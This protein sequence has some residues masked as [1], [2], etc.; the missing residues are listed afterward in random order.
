MVDPKIGLAINTPV[1][2]LTKYMEY[3]D[4]RP[5]LLDGMNV[6]DEV[7]ETLNELAL[8]LFGKTIMEEIEDDLKLSQAYFNKLSA[9]GVPNLLLSVYG[10]YHRLRTTLV[11][12]LKTSP[13]SILDSDPYSLNILPEARPIPVKIFPN[14]TNPDDLVEK[15]QKQLIGSEVSQDI[16]NDLPPIEWTVS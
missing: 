2:R 9:M 6:F 11:E 3:F 1:G 8:N 5:N 15:G 16:L 13:E 12:I 14:G 10:S 7:W 4:K